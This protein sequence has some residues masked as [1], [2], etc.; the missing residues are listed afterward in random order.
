MESKRRKRVKSRQKGNGYKYDRS[1]KKRVAEQYLNSDYTLMELGKMHGIPYQ[2][3]SEWA[4]EFFGELAEQPP[5]NSMENKEPSKEKQ[6]L[7]DESLLKQ[8]AALKKELDY[9]RMKTFALET[10]IDLAKSELGIDVRKN[11]GAKQPK[12]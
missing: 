9:E 1:F 6:N 3:I 2:A 11:S 5:T 10:M 7:Q 8:I 4:Y 12:K